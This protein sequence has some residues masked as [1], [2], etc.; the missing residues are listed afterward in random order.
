MSVHALKVSGARDVLDERTIM[1]VRLRPLSFSFL[2]GKEEHA[3]SKSRFLLV[4]L[5][6]RETVQ[7][8]SRSSTNQSVMLTFASNW[9]SLQQ[10]SPSSYQ[11]LGSAILTWR[12]QKVARH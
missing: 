5:R 10:M 12:Q 7:F 2:R 9:P 11:T 3:G 8:T 6:F 4:C 1:V